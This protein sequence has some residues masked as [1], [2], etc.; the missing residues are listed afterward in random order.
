MLRFSGG[1]GGYSFVSVKGR[2]NKGCFLFP[3]IFYNGNFFLSCPNYGYRACYCWFCGIGE[4]EK[5]EKSRGRTH[6]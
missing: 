1:E 2:Y 3:H 5:Y 6:G 4:Q